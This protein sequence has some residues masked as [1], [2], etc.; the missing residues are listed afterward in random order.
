MNVGI[1]LPNTKGALLVEATET[2]G[3]PKAKTVDGETDGVAVDCQLELKK[4]EVAAPLE[5]MVLVCEGEAEEE[6]KPKLK[7]ELNNLGEVEEL[8]SG[9]LEFEEPNIEL[10]EVKDDPN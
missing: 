3:A 7:V 10:L 4:L 2:E 1:P 8:N 5:L 6:L 9:L